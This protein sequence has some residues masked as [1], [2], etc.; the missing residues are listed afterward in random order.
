MHYTESLEESGTADSAAD[1]PSITVE[2]PTS[3]Q[4]AANQDTGTLKKK[5]R[6]NKTLAASKLARKLPELGVEMKGYMYRKKPGLGARWDKTYCVLTFQAMYFTSMSDNE[7][8]NHMLSLMGDM[9]KTM[10]ESKGRDRNS[11]VRQ[12]KGY[13][14]FGDDGMICSWSRMI[15]FSHG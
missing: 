10:S 4:S 2:E 13:E 3:P 12:S 5:Q 6:D 7:E 15:G 1:V 11:K 14:L 9:Q 8:Y